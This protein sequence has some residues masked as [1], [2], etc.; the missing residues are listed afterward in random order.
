[1][2]ITIVVRL[3]VDVKGRSFAIVGWCLLGIGLLSGCAGNQMV[4]DSFDATNRPQLLLPGANRA[5]VKGLAMGSAR[6]KGWTIVQSSDDRLVMQRP[7]NPS[8]PSALAL[9]SAKSSVPPVIEVT[10]AF[11][12]QSGGVNVALG[13]TLITQSPG[14]KSPKRTDYTENYR[15]A[16]MQSLGS[17]RTNWTANRQRV[18]NAMPTLSPKSESAPV[19]AAE[20]NPLAQVWG[21]TVAEATTAGSGASGG[22]DAPAAESDHTPAETAPSRDLAATSLPPTPEPATPAPSGL[23]WSTSSPAPVVDGS[24]AVAG[25]LMA[26]PTPVSVAR[27]T[28]LAQ[29]TPEP[30]TAQQEAK[31]ARPEA[32][33]ATKTAVPAATAVKAE[34]RTA[35]PATQTARVASKPA[36]AGAKTAKTDPKTAKPTPKST[37]TDPK[38][39]KPESKIAKTDPKTAKPEAKIAKADTKTA[40]PAPKSTKTDSKAAKPASKSTKTDSKAAK[41]ETK[42][43]KAD[44]RTAK[45]EPKNAKADTKTAKPAPKSTKTDS[46]AAKPASKSTKTDKS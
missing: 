16:L 7:L 6:A 26:A 20:N 40:K 23:Q 45:P 30:T 35:K 15:D 38:A 32:R 13:A 22:A 46:K 36:A 25:G 5:E 21:E 24:S 12:E 11:M 42:T 27:T 31:V 33:T 41:P 28:P 1:M 43:I 37:K 44:S 29:P 9:E 8:S 19:A 17:L 18:A 39:A 14:E 2:F 4:S 10:S 34:P 3:E